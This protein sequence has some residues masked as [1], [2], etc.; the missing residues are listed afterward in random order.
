MFNMLTV[1]GDTLRWGLHNNVWNVNPNLHLTQPGGNETPSS[2]CHETSFP[3]CSDDVVPR[4]FSHITL[5]T[6]A[7]NT[8]HPTYDKD[9]SLYA[10]TDEN[11]NE[12]HI[13]VYESEPES[14]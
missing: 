13:W 1:A 12:V 3:A 6:L 9:A 4:S 5:R 8:R 2:M 14:F 10:K 11:G 7:S